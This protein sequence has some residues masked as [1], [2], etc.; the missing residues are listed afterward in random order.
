MKKK[1]TNKKRENVGK[2][3]RDLLIKSSQEKHKPTPNESMGELLSEYDKNIHECIEENK[4][5]LQ[6]DFYV[7]VLTKKEKLMKNVIRSYFFARLSC[8]TP[9][10]DQVVYKYD[11]KED[12][13]SFLWVIPDKDTCNHIIENKLNLPKEMWELLSLVL[14]FKDGE[15]FRLAKKLNCEKEDSNLTEKS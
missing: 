15:L 1:E 10:Y 14:K 2:L 4:K 8:P 12:K 9:N 11:I 6:Q 3:A 13:I 5:K 7:V